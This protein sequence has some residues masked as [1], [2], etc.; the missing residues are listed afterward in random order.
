MSG[1]KSW[2]RAKDGLELRNQVIAQSN[3]L[4]IIR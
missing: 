2:I 4:F 3:Q 1:A